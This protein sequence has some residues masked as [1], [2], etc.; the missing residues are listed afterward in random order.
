MSDVHDMIGSARTTEGGVYPVA[1]VY[2]ILYVNACKMVDSRKGDKLFCAELDII[3]SNV[4]DRPKGSRMSWMANLTKHD[5]AP[6]NA[7]A[8]LA[9][10]AGI[11]VENVDAEGSRAAVGMHNPLCGRLVRLDASDTKTR[12]GGHFT[13]CRF[14]TLPDA[15]QAQ[16]DQ[17]WA[18]AGFAPYPDAADCGPP[19]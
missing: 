7:R 19:F 18:R 6:G 11:E 10:A 16:A 4:P 13:L 9:A 3:E 2:P 15:L 12:A 5:A 14:S 17:L 8:F 1:G